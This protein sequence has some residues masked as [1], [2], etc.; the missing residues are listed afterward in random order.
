MNLIIRKFQIEDLQNF[1][2]LIQDKM[3]SEYA[4]FD[5]QFPTDENSIK[6][7]LN[8]FCST[9]E[10]MAVCLEDGK[11][12]IGFVSLNVVDDTTRNLGYC[13]HSA[14]QNKGYASEAALR[15]K[16][17]AKDVL[18]VTKLIAGT[19]DCNLPSVHVLLKTGFHVISKSEGSFA[20]D[21][22]GN[23]ITFMGGSYEC[24]L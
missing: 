14:Y 16:K 8:Y 3:S 23:P 11:K 21:A 17:Y 6:D 18:H 2:S 1:V 7:I 9:E 12:V 13:I 20:N 22:F 5:D 24:I 10:F 4:P 19:A 15:A